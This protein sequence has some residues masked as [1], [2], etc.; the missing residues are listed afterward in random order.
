MKN[1]RAFTLIE[2]LVVISII[3]LLMS[4]LMPALGRVRG[5]AKSITDRANLRQWG[6]CY[7]MYANEN[8]GFYIPGNPSGQRPDWNHVYKLHD[9]Y[10]NMKLLL[11]PMA[12]K[13]NE[14]DR[15]SPFKAYGPMWETGSPTYGPPV[16]DTSASCP[17]AIA[18]TVGKTWGDAMAIT[19]Q[20][21][22]WTSYDAI[23]ESEKYTSY[24][25]NDWVRNDL[26]ATEAQQKKPW[27]R[28][29]ASAKN[30]GNTPLILDGKQNLV[31]KPDNTNN[32]A[33][34]LLPPEYEGQPAGLDAGPEPDPA[35]A[36]K[37]G[38]K[39]ICINRHDFTNNATFL[40]GASRSVGL[41]ELWKL[42]W[43]S[44][45]NTTDPVLNPY[46]KTPTYDPPWPDWMKNLKDY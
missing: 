39:M 19:G 33:K 31:V 40:D 21:S 4:V 27:V 30:A 16:I 29:T 28:S 14:G 15:I 46:I 43:H 25:A 3:A 38:L 24:V 23:P 7:S 44:T 37:E 45:F 35:A 36:L 5:Q 26:C 18:G 22:W 20:P 41:K 11:C 17:L 6:I 13:P 8:E 32:S 2:L 10:K 34:Q 12:T 42:Q 9:Y 1:K